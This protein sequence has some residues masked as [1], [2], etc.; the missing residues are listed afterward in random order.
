MRTSWR[1]AIVG[2]LPAMAPAAVG[3][4]VALPNPGF[5]VAGGG[6][7]DGYCRAGYRAAEGEAMLGLPTG[8]TTYQWG[9]RDSLFSVAVERGAG[10]GGSHALRAENLDATAKAGVYAHPRLEPGRYRL[11]VWVRTMPDQSARVALYLANRYSRPLKVTGEW[12]RVSHET[13]VS[14]LTER[15]EIN[16]QNASGAPSV[17]WFDDLELV[18]IEEVRYRL[19]PDDRPERPR[20]LLF[21]PM[22]INYLRD[23]AADWAA[24]GFRGFLFDGVFWS[25]SSDVWAVDKDPNTRGEDDGLLRELRACNE[26][27]RAV[28]IDS[29][30]IKVAFYEELPDWFDDTRWA[31]IEHNFREAARMGRLSGCAGIAI[32]TEYVAQQ[33]D[34]NWV[35]YADTGRSLAE[36]KQQ[37]RERM[38][39]VVAAMLTEWPEMVLLTLPEGMLHYGPLW[40]DLF[41]GMLGGCAAVDASGGL[42]VMTE[43]TYHVTDP[44]GLAGFPEAIDAWVADECPPPLP[45]YW[46]RRCSVVLGAWPLGY[47]RAIHDADGKFL[48]YS[49]KQETFGDRIVGSYA[50][51]SEWYSADVF[52]V[53]MAGLNTFSPRYNWIYGHGCV[54]WQWSEEE[55][56]RYSAGVH[57]A[58]SNQ[59]LPTVPNLADYFA[60][61]AHPQRAVPVRDVAP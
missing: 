44:G 46:R 50:D 42:H 31:A 23:T 4:A 33:Y 38:R 49:G 27:C 57:P 20:T 56:R 7:V 28:G 45:D 22:N 25:W 11:S 48:G 60:V 34:P 19:V 51:K 10:R 14:E 52:A 12:R 59:T 40:T 61:L 6:G 58:G 30:F 35:G 21:S 13:T 15:A 29:N 3:D 32:D 43:A 41:I 37:V 53:Q 47:Y 36:L 17:V 9:R 24:R 26:A 55:A 8:W 16:I 2:L 54:F 5:E 18:Q 39:T 1:W